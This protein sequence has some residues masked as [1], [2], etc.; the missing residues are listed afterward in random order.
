MARSAYRCVGDRLT[1]SPCAPAPGQ[2]GGNGSDSAA[3]FEICPATQ[4]P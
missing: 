2:D 3:D 1:A 4:V